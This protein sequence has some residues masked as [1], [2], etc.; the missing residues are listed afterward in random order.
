MSAVD[1]R[2][3]DDSVLSYPNSVAGCLVQTGHATICPSGWNDSM[4]KRSAPT[5]PQSCLR[6]STTTWLGGITLVPLL[7][8]GCCVPLVRSDRLDAGISPTSVAAADCDPL[9]PDGIYAACQPALH[10]LA[11]PFV[12]RD[13]AEQYQ[14]TIRPPHAKFHPVPTRPVF[15]SRMSVPPLPHEVVSVP[16]EPIVPWEAEPQMIQPERFEARSSLGT[17]FPVAPTPG[18]SD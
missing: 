16:M 6:P 5:V 15:A 4:I 11:G 12:P 8:A 10:F 14:S 2:T 7:L 9:I 1:Q 18:V 3:V 17:Q 13:A